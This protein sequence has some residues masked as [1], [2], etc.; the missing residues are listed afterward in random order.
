[1]SQYGIRVRLKD[2]LTMAEL[3][4]IE[5][6]ANVG[7]DDQPLSLVRCCADFKTMRRMYRQLGTALENAERNR[8]SAVGRKAE[9]QPEGDFAN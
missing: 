3:E 2:T 5:D 6:A 4:E 8:R 1:M 9:Y 7:L